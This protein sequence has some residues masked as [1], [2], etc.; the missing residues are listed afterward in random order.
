MQPGDWYAGFELFNS[1]YYWEAHEVWEGLWQQ[2]DKRSPDSLVLRGLIQM[3]ACQVKVRQGNAR[4]EAILRER[5]AA[6][7]EAAGRSD[8]ARLFRENRSPKL[9][10]WE[11]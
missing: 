6:T 3:A 4:G 1:G 10:A 2:T 9:Q 8:L 5:A 11:R 7:M